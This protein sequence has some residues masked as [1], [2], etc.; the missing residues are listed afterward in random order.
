[1]V[2]GKN[3]SV[4]EEGSADKSTKKKLVVSTEVEWLPNKKLEALMGQVH[5]TTNI[6]AK[7]FEK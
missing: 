5:T 2:R 7:T 6:L 1:L 4:R 3:K